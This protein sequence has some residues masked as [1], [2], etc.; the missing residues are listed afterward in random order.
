MVND[1][2]GYTFVD[3][4]DAPAKQLFHIDNST[5]LIYLDVNTANTTKFYMLENNAEEQN[6]VAIEFG[7]DWKMS[8]DLIKIKHQN[9]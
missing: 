4:T 7:K 3:E 6:L 8:L 5:F 2:K 1:K 9:T